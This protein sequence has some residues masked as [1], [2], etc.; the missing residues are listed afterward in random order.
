MR[1]ALAGTL[2]AV[3][4]QPKLLHYSHAHSCHVLARCLHFCIS[5]SKLQLA[6]SF[7][8]N[9]AIFVIVIITIIVVL[10]VRTERMLKR[11][12]AA[13]RSLGGYATSSL[14]VTDDRVQDRR[15]PARQLD[16]FT[17]VSQ[18]LDGTQRIGE[19][20]HAAVVPVSLRCYL[21]WQDMVGLGLLLQPPA[22]T[23]G[24]A[25]C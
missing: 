17:T 20:V 8:L 19:N 10:G 21:N 16:V 6:A 23:S 18:V 11:L 2:L 7:H 5:K 25:S 1:I 22:G 12:L 3:S 13:G 15:D 24:Q 9:I 4:V 14:F